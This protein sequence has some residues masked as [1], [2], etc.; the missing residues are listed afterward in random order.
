M[1]YRV[2]FNVPDMTI[3][4]RGV[5][6]V[7]QAITG[8]EYEADDARVGPSQELTLTRIGRPS[9]GS[10]VQF[11]PAE[12]VIMFAPGVWRTVAPVEQS[13]ERE[14]MVENPRRRQSKAAIRAA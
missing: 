13:A 14:P 9:P 4:P 10:E 3:D 11:V 1:K 7:K 5:A 2:T 12:L 6:S 8:A